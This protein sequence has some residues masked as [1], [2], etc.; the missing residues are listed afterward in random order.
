LTKSDDG[1]LV[2]TG[3]TSSSTLYTRVKTIVDETQADNFNITAGTYYITCKSVTKYLLFS[4]SLLSSRADGDVMGVDPD[5][6]SKVG[7]KAEQKSTSVYFFTTYIW[8]LSLGSTS[9]YEISEW[10]PRIPSGGGYLYFNIASDFMNSLQW[11]YI[12]LN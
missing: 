1:T 10:I 5:N 9:D 2:V 3:Y 6:L 8:G 12:S 4:G 7:Y 11:R